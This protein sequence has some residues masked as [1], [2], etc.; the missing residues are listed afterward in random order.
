MTDTLQ[1][2]SMWKRISAGLFDGI[3]LAVVA[4]LCAWLISVVVHYDAHS[5]SLANAYAR[6][7]EQYGVNFTTAVNDYDTLTE[8]EIARVDEAYAALGTDDEAMY[9]YEMLLQL[10]LVIASLGILMAYLIMEFAVP[11][12]LGNGQTF[13]KKIF[14]I[15]LM[16]QDAT[17][18]SGVSLFIRSILGKYTIETMIPVLLILMMSFGAIGVVAPALIAALLVAEIVMII[19]T[20]TNSLIHDK[21]SSTVCVDVGSQ[22]IFASREELIA[23]KQRQHAEAAARKP[24]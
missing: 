17:R 21:I 24:Y 4:V 5:Q 18:I 11:R 23:Y 3:L 8:E 16:H 1:K 7:E 22:R 20:R 9:H 12:I 13:G 15:G 10:T 6:Y 19:A 2:A 14:G